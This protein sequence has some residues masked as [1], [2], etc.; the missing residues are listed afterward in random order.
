M[1]AFIDL[2]VLIYSGWAKNGGRRQCDKISNEYMSSDSSSRTG[3]HQRLQMLLQ[4]QLLL[5]E[6][7]LAQNEATASRG[8]GSPGVDAAWRAAQPTAWVSAWRPRSLVHGN[9]VPSFLIF[10]C[11]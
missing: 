11:T 2:C 3:E 9:P 10:P 5:I 1:A 7:G 6:P 4:S 8:G